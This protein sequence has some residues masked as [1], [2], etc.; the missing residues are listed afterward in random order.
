[1]ENKS[2]KY[3]KKN[4]CN[5][6]NNVIKIYKKY[7]DFVYKLCNKPHIYMINPMESK[8][9]WE[10]DLTRYQRFKLNDPNYKESPV[11]YNQKTIT[12]N[13]VMIV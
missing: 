12:Q 9:I 7:F 6:L 2:K 11:I 1:M 4:K 3:S 8:L 10:K 5:K 13:Y